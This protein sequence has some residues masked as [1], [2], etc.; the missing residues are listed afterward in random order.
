LNQAS[1]VS[2]IV[3]TC[4]RRSDLKRCLNSLMEQTFQDFEIIVIDNGST[5]GTVE[6]LKNYPAIVIKNDTKNLSHLFN[7]GWRNASGDII[8]YLNDDAEVEKQWLEIIIDTFRRFKKA[9]TVGGPT[10]ATNIPQILRLYNRAQNRKFR[11]LCKIYHAVVLENRLFDVGVFGKSGAYSIGGGLSYSINLKHPILVDFLSFTGAAVK[12]SII[13]EIGGFDEN[14]FWVHLDLDFFLRV[15]NAGYDIIFNPKAIIWHH[16]NPSGLTRSAYY[17]GRDLAILYTK[18]IHPKSPGVWL[19]FMLNVIS[20]NALWVYKFISSS[21][22]K[23]LSGIKG[24]VH[25]ISFCRKAGKRINNIQRQRA[26]SRLSA[27][28]KTT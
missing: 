7:L 1:R 26:H 23:Y 3:P 16:V 2:V 11:F 18:H 27:I 13:Q 12:K 4:N 6:L 25:G 9:G 15:K 5:D 14:F 10:V 21:D 8:A 20:F 19:R 28:E 22:T 17:L 24:F